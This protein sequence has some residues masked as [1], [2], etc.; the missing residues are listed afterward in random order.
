MRF[1]GRCTVPLLLLLAIFLQL[2][3]AAQGTDDAA[4]KQLGVDVDSSQNSL[5]MQAKAQSG[6]GRDEVE[7]KEGNA[8]SEKRYVFENEDYIYTQ[9]LP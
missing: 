8:G 4:N 9:S 6:K 3:L 7:D 1:S 5:H 2:F